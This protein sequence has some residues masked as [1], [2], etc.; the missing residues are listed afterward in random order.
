M[1]VDVP[2]DTRTGKPSSGGVVACS[3]L[4]RVGEALAV[5][6]GVHGVVLEADGVDGVRVA[7]FGVR[8]SAGDA[9]GV[10]GVGG[11]VVA[12]AGL[13]EGVAV[14]CVKV[15]NGMVMPLVASSGDMVAA[16]GVWVVGGGVVDGASAADAGAAASRPV[17]AATPP[18]R[19][20]TRAGRSAFFSCLMVMGLASGRGQSCRSVREGVT[21]TGVAGDRRP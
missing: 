17:A 5:T 14:T 9:D 4:L 2:G 16:A 6:S 7:G 15:K 13:L 3:A 11:V 12:A 18:A 1:R 21:L 10:E 19:T 20:A 8:A